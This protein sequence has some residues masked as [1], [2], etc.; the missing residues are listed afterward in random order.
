MKSN[1]FFNLAFQ[2]FAILIT[3]PSDLL[4]FKRIN[5][6]ITAH[7]YNLLNLKGDIEK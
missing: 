2:Y 1:I 7:A 3:L 4:G 6:F 5:K